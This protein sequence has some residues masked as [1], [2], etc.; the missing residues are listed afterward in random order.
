MVMCVRFDTLVKARLD[1]VHIC[2]IYS[3]LNVQERSMKPSIL[4]NGS[5][6]FYNNNIINK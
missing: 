1:K 5:R 2:M 4:E 6:M 3:S